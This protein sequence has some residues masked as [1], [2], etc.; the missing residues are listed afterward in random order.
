MVVR[1]PAHGDE[2]DISGF[3]GERRTENP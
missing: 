2:A 1:D 3:V